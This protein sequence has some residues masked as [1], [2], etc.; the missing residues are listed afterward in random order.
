MHFSKIRLLMLGLGGLV[1]L[2][3]ALAFAYRYEIVISM[4]SRSH[5]GECSAALELRRGPRP[6]PASVVYT[7]AR[8]PCQVRQ[9]LGRHVPHKDGPAPGVRVGAG[10]DVNES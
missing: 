6:G 5:I 9:A 4:V 8:E 2:G 3:V 10:C 1:L 7:E